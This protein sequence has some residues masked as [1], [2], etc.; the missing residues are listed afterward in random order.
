[1]LT[2]RKVWQKGRKAILRF[3]K[4]FWSET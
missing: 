2:L 3:S 4:M 1:M